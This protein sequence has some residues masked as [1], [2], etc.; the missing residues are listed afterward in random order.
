MRFGLG[1]RALFFILQNR[2]Q[3]LGILYKHVVRILK[4]FEL[5]AN[6]YVGLYVGS[7]R[8]TNFPMNLFSV[9]AFEREIN[10]YSDLTCFLNNVNETHETESYICIKFSYKGETFKR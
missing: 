2:K 4:A 3:N 6:Y 8:I 5:C 7:K 9:N 10:Q 1:S